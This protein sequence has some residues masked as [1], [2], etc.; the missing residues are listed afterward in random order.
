MHE[1]NRE[2]SLVDDINTNWETIPFK[3]DNFYDDFE[4]FE[5]REPGNSNETAKKVKCLFPC[6]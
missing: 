3:Y 6:V 1:N 4:P 5:T 2:I